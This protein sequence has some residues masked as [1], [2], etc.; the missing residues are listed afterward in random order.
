M[1]SAQR[2]NRIEGVIEVLNEFERRELIHF[3]RDLET[4]ASVAWLYT[5]TLLHCFIKK[6]EK[7]G[8]F[9]Q[10]DTLQTLNQMANR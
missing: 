5:V 7:K 9:E 2:F 4:S 3:G 1:V 10:N 6:L 8:T